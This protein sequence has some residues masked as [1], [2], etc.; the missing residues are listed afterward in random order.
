MK[1]LLLL[2]LSVL[3]FSGIAF[4]QIDQMGGKNPIT[5]NKLYWPAENDFV[6]TII[7]TANEIGAVYVMP[8]HDEMW[9]I[10][11]PSGIAKDSF[12]AYIIVDVKTDLLLSQAGNQG[13]GFISIDSVKIITPDTLGG[14]YYLN[15]KVPPFASHYQV[16]VDGVTGNAPSPGVEYETWAIF[17]NKEVGNIYKTEKMFFPTEGDM[18]PSIAGTADDTSKG[19][20]L[21]NKDFS[22]MWIVCKPSGFAADSIKAYVV[23]QVRSKEIISAAGNNGVGWVRVDSVLIDTPDTLAGKYYEV[24]KLPPATE[25]RVIINGIT[26]NHPTNSEYETWVIIKE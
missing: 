14:K 26:D 21:P 24:S 2:G 5:I 19:Y 7:T 25:Y 9:T 20:L 18:I 11:K 3:L 16:T 15:T 17:K 4:G 8:D 10:C 12:D 6:P 1:K 22:E 23:L 13:I